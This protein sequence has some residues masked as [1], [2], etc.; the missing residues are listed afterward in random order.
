MLTAIIPNFEVAT[1]YQREGPR[2]KSS[3][4]RK[5][6]CIWSGAGPEADAKKMG[7]RDASGPD[8]LAIIDAS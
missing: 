3:S 7:R 2:E 8:L 6:I 4:N 1:S 5:M